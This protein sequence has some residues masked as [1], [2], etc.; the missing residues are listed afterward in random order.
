MIVYSHRHSLCVIDSDLIKESISI[1]VCPC[2]ATLAVSQP[3]FPAREKTLNPI[4]TAMDLIYSLSPTIKMRN[5]TGCGHT[6]ARK[7]VLA[8]RAHIIVYSA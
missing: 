8:Q 3:Y 7:P 4:S 2:L 1:E 5:Q 6:H